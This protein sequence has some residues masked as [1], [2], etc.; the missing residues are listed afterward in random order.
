MARW[1]VPGGGWQWWGGVAAWGPGGG[2]GHGRGTAGAHKKYEP[3]YSIQHKKLAC[4]FR[5]GTQLLR[6]QLPHTYARPAACHAPAALVIESQRA[7][8]RLVLLPARLG[9]HAGDQ[10]AR[11]A[12]RSVAATR[13]RRVPRGRAAQVPDAHGAVPAA[14]E[15]VVLAQHGEAPLVAA[16]A[17]GER[18]G[19]ARGAAVPEADRAVHAAAR[20]PLAAGR[21]AEDLPTT[22]WWAWEARGCG[23]G[24]M[25]WRGVAGMGLAAWGLRHG[26]PWVAQGCAR[27]PALCPRS[28]RSRCPTGARSGRRSHSP[29]I[30]SRGAASPAPLEA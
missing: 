2:R 28:A 26:V 25:G 21:H 18:G 14:R 19:A 6:R 7:A 9:R 1:R 20:D 30:V 10:A 23:M 17:V 13:G 12:R 8:A 5:L 27:G 16:A 22:G 3:P 24:G 4:V 11:R 29:A 15:E